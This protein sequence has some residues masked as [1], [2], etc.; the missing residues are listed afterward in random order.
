MRGGGTM[1]QREGS[2]QN[3]GKSLLGQ[4]KSRGQAVKNIVGIRRTAHNPGRSAKTKFKKGTEGQAL[5][6][7]RVTGSVNKIFSPGLSAGRILSYWRV[8]IFYFVFRLVFVFVQFH[9]QSWVH[10]LGDYVELDRYLGI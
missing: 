5:S 2:G 10:P 9:L 8:V 7:Y 1:C 3:V 4:G 6:P